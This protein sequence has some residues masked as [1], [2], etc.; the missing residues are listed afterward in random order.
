MSHV[1]HDACTKDVCRP[2]RREVHVSLERKFSP[3]VMWADSVARAMS[4]DGCVLQYE[5]DRVSDRGG[6]EG[7]TKSSLDK[8]R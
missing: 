8:T 4:A 6:L 3:Q 2:L 1:S 7:R 5:F